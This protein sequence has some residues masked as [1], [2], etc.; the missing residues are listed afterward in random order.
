MKF[1][2]RSC[3]NENCKKHSKDDQADDTG[4]DTNNTGEQIRLFIDLLKGS[5]QQWNARHLNK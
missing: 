1:S 4:N 2:E 5:T 3:K